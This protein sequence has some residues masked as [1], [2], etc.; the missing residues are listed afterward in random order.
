MK[1]TRPARPRKILNLARTLPNGRTQN[2]VRLRLCQR[3][4]KST[5]FVPAPVDD[6]SKHQGRTRSIPYV[7]GQFVA[8]V[9]IPIKLEGELLLML[10][11]VIQSAQA[12]NPAWYS[13]LDPTLNTE[14]EQLPSKCSAHLSLSRP[15]AL[16]AHQRDDFRKEVRKITLKNS[17]FSASF[18]QLTVLTNDEKTRSFLC[19][20]AGAGHQQLK[21]LSDSLTSHLASLRQLPYYAQPRFH[22]SIAW[23]LTPAPISLSSKTPPDPNSSVDVP[24][25]MSKDTLQPPTDETDTFLAALDPLAKQL[26]QTFS[27]RLLAL[28]KFDARSLEVKIG[29]EIHKWSFLPSR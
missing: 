19:V 3:K 5:L 9:Y 2:Q 8:H 10:R 12:A 13:L 26:Q 18:S 27:S 29:K 28:G 7:E 24:T 23:T 1:P 17:Q 14:T 20:E 21:E 11:E 25:N 6:P 4:Q 16:R 22:I 15:V